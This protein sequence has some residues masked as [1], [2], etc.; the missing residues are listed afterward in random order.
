MKNTF[1]DTRL[2]QAAKGLIGNMA[3]QYSPEKMETSGESSERAEFNIKIA[4]GKATTRRRIR[5]TTRLMAAVMIL[6]IGVA[7][8]FMLGS[9]DIPT[10]FDGSTNGIM[11][12]RGDAELKAVP[13]NIYFDRVEEPDEDIGEGTRE[14]FGANGSKKIF[15]GNIKITDA[16]TGEE[17]YVFSKAGIWRI[18]EDGGG[19]IEAGSNG[20]QYKNPG[21]G[22]PLPTEKIVRYGTFTLSSDWRQIHIFPYAEDCIYGSFTGVPARRLYTDGVVITSGVTTR[23]EAVASL[24]AMLDAEW[25]RIN[26][27]YPS[28]G[29]EYKTKADYLYEDRSQSIDYDALYGKELKLEEMTCF[30]KAQEFV[31]L[32]S[33][34][35]ELT[36]G[37]ASGE[38]S[39]YLAEIGEDGNKQFAEFVNARLDE[40]YLLVPTYKGEIAQLSDCDIEITTKDADCY[41]FPR[42]IYYINTD[43]G[44]IK[45][46]VGY[47]PQDMKHTVA[48]NGIVLYTHYFDIL[49]SEKVGIDIAYLKLER[50]ISM[51]IFDGNSY[52]AM[53]TNP[54]RPCEFAE[55]ARADFIY[56]SVHHISIYS[57]KYADDYHTYDEYYAQFK[58]GGICEDIGFIKVPIK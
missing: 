4:K 44:E 54:I 43:K 35:E 53:V 6:V 18:G 55:E 50:G 38:L 26:Q 27:S 20:W 48:K 30:D 51:V 31:K 22:F 2:T 9:K 58:E 11:W 57:D 28:H 37:F 10:V 36:N 52:P 39:N 24:Q 42:I 1:D 8:V 19:M 5:I 3:E 16:N 7:S 23:E 32:Y 15:V 14:I 56:D 33:S 29:E 13:V 34:Y 25:E 17:L 40:N 21:R 46:S 12:I 41:G 49:M 47:L 45:L